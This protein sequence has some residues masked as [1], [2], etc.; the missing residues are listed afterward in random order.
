MLDWQNNQLEYENFDRLRLLT[1]KG[2]KLAD[3]V[4]A[5]YTEY[6]KNNSAENL[7]D[8]LASA[9]SWREPFMMVIKERS[10]NSVL[11]I[12][13]FYKNEM[14]KEGENRVRE[15]PRSGTFHS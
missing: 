13:D 1:T 12:E 4:S 15:I 14:Y 11:K 9:N 7:I 6:I 10:S 5:Y 3:A 2:W 8:K